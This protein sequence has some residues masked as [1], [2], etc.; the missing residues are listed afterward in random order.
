MSY[1]LH[2]QW[3]SEPVERVPVCSGGVTGT[4]Q[5]IRTA[6]K[7]PDNCY[8]RIRSSRGISLLSSDVLY[9]W[10]CLWSSDKSKCCLLM[11][12]LSSRNVS[13]SP[14]Y[15][16]LLPSWH[17]CS[18]TSFPF[19]WSSFSLLV[20]HPFYFHEVSFDENRAPLPCVVICVSSVCMGNQSVHWCELAKYEELLR[21]FFCY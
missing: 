7:I 16:C 15:F 21:V 17:I 6:I 19:F 8:F 13:P 12:F 5:Q 2:G 14:K 18:E 20:L 11:K 3:K 1:L 4:P 9:L 10:G